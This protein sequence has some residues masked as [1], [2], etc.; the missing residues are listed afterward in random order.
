MFDKSL[1]NI[2]SV[3]NIKKITDD[4]ILV[5]CILSNSF[6]VSFEYNI[7]ENIE[8]VIKEFEQELEINILNKT[9]MLD[10]IGLVSGKNRIERVDYDII[11]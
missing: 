7:N 4:V 5:K 2:Q 1:T 10:G 3:C 11:I 6:S 9:N 8:E